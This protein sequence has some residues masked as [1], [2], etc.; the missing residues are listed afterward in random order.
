MEFVRA[1]GIS[2][3]RRHETKRS[4]RVARR[5]LAGCPRRPSRRARLIVGS[6]V[7]QH[8]RLRKVAADR[9]VV[10]PLSEGVDSDAVSRNETERTGR[11]EPSLTPQPRSQIRV[12]P[13]DSE[14][15]CRG[16]DS[17]RPS[18]F[19]RVCWMAYRGVSRQSNRSTL[20]DGPSTNVP[21]LIVATATPPSD[22]TCT[23]LGA[24]GSSR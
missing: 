11:V 19:R 3:Y 13:E 6:E 21:I 4:A 17:R 9:R 5:V 14:S 1:V 7:G 24:S 2:I 15:A 20:P 23:A 10:S 18:I 12:M 16:F 8:G 22:L